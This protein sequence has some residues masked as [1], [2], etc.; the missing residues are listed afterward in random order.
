MVLSAFGVD[1]E[2]SKLRHLA[3]CTPFGT[4]AFQLV[5]AARTLGFATSRKHTFASIDDLDR[6]I[7]GGLLPIVYVDLWPIRGGL[8]WQY[9]SLVVQA[10]AHERVVVLDPLIGERAI[11]TADFLSAWE[12]MRCLTIVVNE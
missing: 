10:V 1:I 11:P 9:H 7:D 8:S 5:E 3:D 2:E 4:D 12:E 6:V